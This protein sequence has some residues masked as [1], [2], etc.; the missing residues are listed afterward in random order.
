MS[1][2]AASRPRAVALPGPRWTPQ[3]VVIMVLAIV[4]VCVLLYPSAASWFADRKHATE[5]NGYVHEVAAMAPEEATERLVGARE[6]NE[7]LPNG[8]L[9]D[10]YALDADGQESETSAGWQEYVHALGE[11]PGGIMGRVRIPA[12]DVDLPIFHGTDQDT[13]NQ[14]VGHLYGSGLP[15]GGTGNHS[16]LT[17]HSGMVNSRLFTDLPRLKTGDVFSVTVLNEE[18]HYRVD[19]IETVEPHQTESLRRIPGADY[20]T[21]VTCTPTGVN[22]HRLL[23]RGE[24]I[25]AD[26]ARDAG[27]TTLPNTTAEPGFPWWATGLLGAAI[28][29]FLIT[30]PRHRMNNPGSH[31]DSGRA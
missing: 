24:R 31:Q 3:R 2:P 10:P 12:I 25:D 5:V 17:A 26:T 27:V 11:L 13:L 20:V 14:G 19:N 8:P 4:G 22:T 1:A 15:V 7:Y 30:R 28:T 23:V 16:V 6:Y 9:R 18:F 21:L 29:V